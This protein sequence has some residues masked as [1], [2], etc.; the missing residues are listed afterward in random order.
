M[1]ALSRDCRA[2]QNG[3]CRENGVPPLVR[4][5]RWSRTTE[6]TLLGGVA[7]LRALCIGNIWLVF[8][9]H[10]KND[11]F[12]HQARY[13]LTGVAHTNNRHSQNVIYG[14]KAV[15][16]LLELLQ[17]HK[18]LQVKVYKECVCVSVC[19]TDTMPEPILKYS[20]SAVFKHEW[21]WHNTETG[22][23]ISPRSSYRFHHIWYQFLWIICCPNRCVNSKSK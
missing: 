6:N 7:A 20:S 14:E 21:M 1:I 15:P 4:L 18:S 2:H 3:L 12:K 8:K 10:I 23:L 16:T 13:L 9:Y 19:V 11:S 5:L 17:N 22:D